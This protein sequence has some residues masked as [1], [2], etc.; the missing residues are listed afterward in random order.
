MTVAPSMYEVTPFG[1]MLAEWATNGRFARAVAGQLGF[2]WQDDTPPFCGQ[3]GRMRLAVFDGAIGAEEVRLALSALAEKE[4][5]TIVAQSVL[6]EAEEALAAAPK[7][8]L[9]RKAP[10]DLLTTAAQRAR[11]V[12]RSAEDTA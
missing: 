8:S 2:D 12:I 5:V 3:R 9:I 6:P 1:V 7:G 10:R 11:R 4:R